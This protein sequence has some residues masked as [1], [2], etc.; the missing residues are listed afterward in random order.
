MVLDLLGG[1]YA[2][3]MSLAPADVGQVSNNAWRSTRREVVD[4]AGLHEARAARTLRWL[5]PATDVSV[6]VE[7]GVAVAEFL[8]E[9]GGLVV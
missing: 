7:A 6:P 8:S 4:P 9:G 1:D 5:R 3:G 2:G